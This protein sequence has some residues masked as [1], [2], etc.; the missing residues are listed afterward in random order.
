ML[1]A[2]GVEKEIF[3]GNSFSTHHGY[4]KR[5]SLQLEDSKLH[6]VEKILFDKLKG[7]DFR[8]VFLNMSRHGFAASICMHGYGNDTKETL[9]LIEDNF[10]FKIQKTEWFSGFSIRLDDL[11][12][13]NFI[14][15]ELYAKPDLRYMGLDRKT[16]NR[17]TDIRMR[18]KSKF[19][20]LSMNCSNENVLYDEVHLELYFNSD[21]KVLEEMLNT[22]REKYHIDVDKFSEKILDEIYRFSHLKFMLKNGEINKIKYYRSKN[23]FLPDYYYDES[24]V[25][26]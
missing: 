26:I 18:M 1:R 14:H 13:E 6:R 24:P 7:I 21:K 20:C 3:P 17:I 22:L 12:K 2:I 8:V 15:R 5:L 16:I 9:R 11:D 19:I 4:R 25:Y 23:V 10:N